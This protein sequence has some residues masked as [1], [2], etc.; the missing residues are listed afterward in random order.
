MATAARM[1][2]MTTKGRIWNLYS[3]NMMTLFKA[4]RIAREKILP[5]HKLAAPAIP[6]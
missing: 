1:G 4:C 3:K 6:T 5:I 2:T